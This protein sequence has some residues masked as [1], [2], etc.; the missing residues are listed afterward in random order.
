[1]FLFLFVCCGG[2]G[3]GDGCVCCLF[4][5]L[6]GNFINHNPLREIRVPYLVKGKVQ[7]FSVCKITIEMIDK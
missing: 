3:G 5:F 6:F 1:M 2:G 7:G 4:Y